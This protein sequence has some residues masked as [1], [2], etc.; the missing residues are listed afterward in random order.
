MPRRK[1]T[2]DSQRLLP[3]ISIATAASVIIIV[4]LFSFIYFVASEKQMANLPEPD[5]ANAKVAPTVKNPPK[6]ETKNVNGDRVI[7]K[8]VEKEPA[9]EP[10][11]LVKEM[12]AAIEPELITVRPRPA[13]NTDNIVA[14][15]TQP[16]LEPFRVVKIRLPL[17]LELKDLDQQYPRQ[18]LREELKRDEVIRVDLFCK[19]NSRAAELLNAAFKA[20]GQQLLIDG[21]A[22]DRLK[23]KQKSDYVYFTESM[24]AEEIAQ[25]LEQLGADD[26]KAE[27]KKAGDGQFDRFMLAP[28]LPADVAELAKAL[29]VPVSQ[30]KLPKPKA[31]SS[32]DPRRSLESVT[33][34]QLAAN[35]PKAGARAG[36]KLTLVLPYGLTNHFPQNS[37]EIKSFL[38]K[39][40]ERK[41]NT[42][43]LMLVLQTI[44]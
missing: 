19:E 35:L 5:R 36:D 9:E 8:P 16:E 38:D 28:F 29:G 12:P 2:W 25:L 44:N 23:R 7:V 30:V 42:L 43:P 17:L 24:T 6:I 15:P 14:T 34:A 4:S 32:I 1:P 31:L 10:S 40:S 20:R 41:P 18:K 33:A 11:T 26:K 27:L 21:I 3:W 39:R 37:K 13:T 22:Q